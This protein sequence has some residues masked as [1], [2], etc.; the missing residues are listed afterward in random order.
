MHDGGSFYTPLANRGRLS[1]PPSRRCVPVARKSPKAG[2]SF[3][4]AN[5]RF[6]NPAS[7]TVPPASRGHKRRNPTGDLPGSCISGF[8]GAVRAC[9]RLRVSALVLSVGERGRYAWYGQRAIFLPR[10]RLTRRRFRLHATQLQPRHEIG[11]LALDWTPRSL[12][13][14]LGELGERWLQRPIRGAR[15]HLP[16]LA[17]LSRSVPVSCASR[18]ANSGI[19]SRPQ[20]HT[21]CK[22]ATSG[23]LTGWIGLRTSLSGESDAALRPICVALLRLH[24]ARGA[25]TRPERPARRGGRTSARSRRLTS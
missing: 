18:G 1:P 3:A 8:T 13:F 5:H 14:N 22:Q 20:P 9:R 19:A 21:R 7:A 24:R 6:A 12:G 23:V 10:D 17:E 16:G 4:N 2:P 25:E 11:H 15:M